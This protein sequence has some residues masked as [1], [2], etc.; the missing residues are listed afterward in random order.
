MRL[1]CDCPRY[2]AEMLRNAV[3]DFEGPY[4]FV[5]KIEKEVRG[6]RAFVVV[7]VVAAAVF[8]FCLIYTGNFKTCALF[9]KSMLLYHS[10]LSSAFFLAYFFASFKHLRRTSTGPVR[11]GR[12]RGRGYQQ[13]TQDV[14]LYPAR[15]GDLSRRVHGV[16][17]AAAAR[18]GRIILE[19][20]HPARA[21]RRGLGSLAGENVDRR[22]MFTLAS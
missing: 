4:G 15:P 12:V 19:R 13:G 20:I 21:R 9:F 6:A 5:A 8:Q 2:T 7:C 22:I 18:R 14:S 10:L 3:A 17:G 1:R 16:G 11:F